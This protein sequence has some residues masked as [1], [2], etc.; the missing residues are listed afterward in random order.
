VLTF[1]AHILSF[2]SILFSLSPW[3]M[4]F[5][6]TVSSP[7]QPYVA[8][9]QRAI[10]HSNIAQQAK[11]TNSPQQVWSPGNDPPKKVVQRVSSQS[12]VSLSA[13]APITGSSSTPQAP[14]QV[15]SLTPENT[16]RE[17]KAPHPSPSLDTPNQ[18]LET[19]HQPAIS[20]E[21]RSPKLA[22]TANLDRRF[23]QL[24]LSFEPNV[25]Q[26]DEQVKFVSRGRGYTLFLTD[27]EAVFSLRQSS[28]VKR[29]ASD[30]DNS[31]LNTQ[32]L[33]PTTQSVVRMKFEGAADP[34]KIYGTE[35]LPG[36]V[37]YFIGKDESRWRTNIPTF[38]KVNYQSIYPGI[39]LA[40]YGNEGKLEYDLIVQ[41]GADP[42]QIKLAF[43]GTEK[44]D[45]D[46]ASGDLILTLANGNSSNLDQSE[47]GGV[48]LHL[49]KPLVYQ[50]DERGHK[51]LIAGN[52]LVLASNLVTGNPVVSSQQSAM[53]STVFIKLASY[54]QSRPLVIDPV[55]NFATYLGGTVGD[56]AY[57]VAVDRSGMAYVT[58]TTGSNDFPTVNNFQG[59]AGSYDAFVTKFS[60]TGARIYST[61]IG[62]SND[63]Q[64][65]G[66][67][68]DHAGEAYITGTTSSTNFPTANP[69]QASSGGNYDVFVT[70]LT[71]AGTLSYS[72][73]LGGSLDEQGRDI[74]VDSGGQYYVA[75]FTVSTNFPTLNAS[76]GT[77]GGGWI[78]RN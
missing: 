26:T 43:S 15:A 41:P 12:A 30:S 40:Y 55:I 60:E 72:T 24:P 64:G 13:A 1:V 73:Y 44:I 33:A 2:V 48:T 25:G 32:Q 8:L 70:K 45:V 34:P 68:V 56:Q 62:G 7:G 46:S 63:D 50:L 58:G 16:A 37:N 23:G 11:P 31:A 27:R 14:V 22:T 76:Q 57:H 38:E 35:K 51:E 53:G 71:A 19:S 28:D 3:G 21:T 54:D 66:I 17:V 18:K 69:S 65:N 52:Y 49:R 9:N 10:A 39:D 5:A 78:G 20:I 4:G 59:Y 29:E 75:G 61:Y 77:Y 67:A 47:L 74:A 6:L 36:I 42:N